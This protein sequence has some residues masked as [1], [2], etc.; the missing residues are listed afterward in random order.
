MIKK[1]RIK[2]I[3]IA[4]ASFSVALIVI[5][6]YINLSNYA[7]VLKSADKRLLMIENGQF[8]PDEQHEEAPGL[9]PEENTTDEIFKNP[10]TEYTKALIKA[11]KL[12]RT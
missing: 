7:G 5:L 11:S 8:T 10:R 2:F 4:M 9:P 6:G 12:E 1:L 3:V